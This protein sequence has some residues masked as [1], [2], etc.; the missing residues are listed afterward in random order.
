MDTLY[1]CSYGILDPR[2]TPE[3]HAHNDAILNDGST[4]LGIEVTVPEL[5][6]RCGLGNIDPQH[7]GGDAGTAAIEAVLTCPLPPWGTTLVTV[8]A[9]ADA[10][11]AMA[12]IVQ[13]L[14]WWEAG[15]PTEHFR[16]PRVLT[17]AVADKEASGSWPGP[18]PI[19]GAGDLVGPAAVIMAMSADHT[20]PL[21]TRVARMQAWLRGE[22][23]P[24]ESSM[25]EDMRRAARAALRD[26]DSEVR[27][28][29]AVVTG[30]HRLAMGIGYRFAPVV[31]ATNPEF[32]WQGGP[33]HRKHTVSRW[34]SGHPM[35]WH[36]L[37][38]ALREREPGWGGSTSI[39]GSP[40]GEAS[41]LTT[42]DVVDL[43][44]RY[45]I[46]TCPSCAVDAYYWGRTRDDG[47][48]WE[49]PDCGQ[50]VTHPGYVVPPE[51]VVVG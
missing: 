50:H 11:G 31:A 15:S 27:D 13:R 17:I 1:P 4:V 34:N 5:A 49:C 19:D 29:V 47:A 32:S 6:A 44:T 21:A 46:V 2:N 14:E 18:Q 8:R 10:I 41:I 51:R 40:Q 42:G 25:E 23:L 7:L 36:G 20:V 24:G 9:D 16:T 33:A 28:G 12:V 45:L 26:L 3:A 22:Y 48:W 37:E 43:V 30:S 38:A 39:L 35:D